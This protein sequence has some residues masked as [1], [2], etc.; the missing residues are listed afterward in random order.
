MKKDNPITISQ[1][2]VVY[3]ESMR[4]LGAARFVL[5]GVIL[6]FAVFFFW[7]EIYLVGSFIVIISLLVM[8]HCS[9]TIIDKESMLLIKKSGLFIPFLTIKIKSI[10][11]AK[12]MVINVI[13]RRHR[14]F[15]QKMNS[16]STSYKLFFE[17]PDKRILINTF[18]EKSKATSLAKEVSHLLEIHIDKN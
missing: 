3:K 7:I 18:S 2:T 14:G 1:Q 6:F 10:R 9:E 12:S 17:M 16:K 11:N 13:S 15:G 8:E 5:G 4:E